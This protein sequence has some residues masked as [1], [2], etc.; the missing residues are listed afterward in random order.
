MLSNTNKCS[1]NKIIDNII[2]LAAKQALH[3]V[4]SLSDTLTDSLTDP[5]TDS[6]T[7]SHTFSF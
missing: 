2:F 1:L 4:I 6:L 7:D 5:L 3:S